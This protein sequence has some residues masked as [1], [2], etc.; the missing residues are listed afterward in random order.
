MPHHQDGPLGPVSPD[1]GHQ[2]GPLR[3]K[4]QQPGGN[5][6]PFENAFQVFGHLRFIARGTGRIHAD[7]GLKMI[8][9]LLLHPIPGNLI[10]LPGFGGWNKAKG[11]KREKPKPKAAQ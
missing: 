7:K 6:F 5:S 1:A 9:R 4:G 10:P 11:Q 3:V 8:E 2:V